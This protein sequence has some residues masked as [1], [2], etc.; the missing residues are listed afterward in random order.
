MA[1]NILLREQWGDNFYASLDTYS[2]E[3]IKTAWLTLD[4]LALIESL[5]AASSTLVARVFDSAGILNAGGVYFDPSKPFHLSLG[6]SSSVNTRYGFSLSTMKTMEMTPGYSGNSYVEMNFLNQYWS[7]LLHERKSRSWKEVRYSEVVNEIAEEIGF[8]D[9]Q[10]EQTKGRFDVIQ[11]YWSNYQLLQWMAM[12]SVNASGIPGYELGVRADGTFFFKTFNRLF[13]QKPKNQ[14]MIAA[15]N[16]DMTPDNK[17]DLGFHFKIEQNYAYMVAR[18]AGGVTG[19]YF[20]W[21]TKTFHRDDKKVS[22][23]PQSQ[24]SDWYYLAPS[25]ETSPFKLD[26]GRDMETDAQAAHRALQAASSIQSITL[27][28][29]G[30]TD[31]KIGDLVNLV[32]LPS[33]AFTEKIA[34]IHSG[35][36]MISQT[37]HEI[38]ARKNQFVTELRLVRQGPNVSTLDGMELTKSVTGKKLTPIK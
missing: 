6:Q 33:E 25:H 22:E 13:E 14:I 16:E 27:S 36:Y 38:H 4:N 34:R 31:Y 21:D 26:G 8:E 12:R 37:S 18:G 28:V 23:S 10:I 15:R 19:Q 20:D 30:N 35:Y 24:L 1:T 3:E 32:I 7:A 11:P 9:I 2:S 29:A 17:F 5:S